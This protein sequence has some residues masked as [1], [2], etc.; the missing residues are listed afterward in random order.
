MSY[1]SLAPD[2]LREALITGGLPPLGAAGRR[3]LPRDLRAHARAQ[4]PLLRALPDDRERVR[5]LLEPARR[6]GRPA[7]RRRPPDRA[8]FRQ[9]GHELGMSDG[10][11]TLHYML[12]LPLDSPAFLH[13]VEAAT[14]FAR[15]PIYALLHEAC[16]AD[17][18]ATRWS[19]ER[20]LPAEFDDGR[21]VHRR[22]RLPVDVRGVRGAARRCARRAE[23]LAEHEWP[24]LYDPDVL[25]ANE[26]P[27]AAAIYATTCTSSASL[28][29]DR[30]PD[31]RRCGL[32][33]QRVRAQRP[34]RR[35]RAHPRPAARARPRRSPLPRCSLARG[36]GR[37]GRCR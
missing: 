25:R 8:A 28:G 4:P 30:R 20:M 18:G 10:A 14:A 23:L 26:V 16:Y 34:A 3:R 35:R 33:D 9:L 31:P 6:R 19:A 13:D 1:L 11:E 15:N 36:T 37:S 29:G 24:Q 5:A 21:P 17:G 27:A 7:A 12:E 32:G 2:G 22:A